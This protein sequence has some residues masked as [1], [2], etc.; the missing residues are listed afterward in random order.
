LDPK[1]LPFRA[2]LRHPPDAENPKGSPTSLTG[3]ITNQLPVALEEA[4]LIYGDGGAMP[5]YITLGRIE[6][7]QKKEIAITRNQGANDLGGPQWVPP[8]S[9]RPSQF[10]RFGQT[11]PANAGP[12]V[13]SLKR[14]LFYDVSSQAELLRNNSLK[15]L[16]QKW[17]LAKRSDQAV[18][19]AR[20][21]PRGAPNASPNKGPAE[22][23]NQEPWTPT[24]LWLGE[25]PDSG[26]PRPNLWGT[27]QQE[28]YIRVF[29]SVKSQD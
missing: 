5:R 19:F 3:S 28:T 9:Q 16:D 17:R 24:R 6:P 7:N 25:L 14:A 26:Q 12:V 27:L 23:I 11:T 29:L 13:D 15:H 18:L 1:H 4:Y 10:N 22:K 8:S 20:I 2:E 21:S